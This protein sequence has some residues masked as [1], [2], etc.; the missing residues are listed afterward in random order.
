MK[1]I[2]FIV[3]SFCLTAM[4]FAQ[5]KGELKLW[6]NTP[7]KLWVEALPLGNGRIGAMVYGDPVH[8]QFQL[9]EET[10][11][12]GSPYNNTNPLAKDALSEIRQLIFEGKNAEAQKLCGPSICSQGANGMPYQ[13]LGSLH[14][15]FENIDKYENYYRELDIENATSKTTFST[16][17]INYTREAF[18][19][20]PDQL[21]IIRLTASKK[22]SISFT[23]RYTTPYKDATRSISDKMLRIDGKA[24]D[25]EKIEGK[26][27][28]AALTQINNNGGK[29][30]IT[31]DTTIR[32]TNAN[33]VILYVSMGT[34][35]INYKDVSGDALKTTKEYLKKANKKTFEKYLAAH[36]AYYRNFFDRVSLDLGRNAQADKTTDVRVSEFASTFDP[37][38][39]ALYFQFGR[40]LLICSS[41]PGGQAANL[42]GIWNYQLRAP[43][44]GKYTTDI[45]VEMNYWPAE[46][47]NL[48]EMHEPF[49]QLVKDVAQTGKES[50]AM[51]GCRGWTL[52]HNT[53][54]WRSTGAVDGP[55]YGIWPTCNA[56]FCQHLW[57]RYLFS[58]DKKYLNEVYPYMRDA[59]KFYLDF[60]VREPKNGWL[61]VAP[62]YSPENAPNVDGKRSWVVTAG[63]TMDN[64]MVFDLFSNTIQAAS[65]VNENQNF[66]DSL[67]TIVSQLPPM[68]VGR[69]GQL[70]EW[71]SDW[72]NPKDRHRHVSHLWGLY[73]GYQI[74]KFESPVLFEAAKKSLIHRG[75]PS[76][77]WSM[78]W[79]VCLWA[80]LLDGNHAYKLIADQLKPTVDEKGQNGGTY[81]N[82]FDAHPPFQI[83]GN[84]GC[85][86]GIA[87]ML[88]QSHGGAVHLLPAL[89]DVWSKGSVKGL[90]CRGGFELKEL[91]WE[92][93]KIKKAVIKSTQGGVLRIRS[94]VQL[95]LN[96]SALKEANGDNDNALFRM[97]QVRK[98]QVAA[99]A[100]INTADEYKSYLFDIVTE[101]GSSYTL[102]N[103]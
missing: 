68:Q 69:W 55:G 84:F 70:Q 53:D 99:S 39:A 81:P 62:S 83:D 61:V 91:T 38:L 26:V 9:N 98:P 82:L 89:P 87:E 65:L 15:D 80:R 54:I 73:P 76:T 96:G 22:N 3:L 25:H 92:N 14:L 17:G 18:T 29:L 41:Q 13:T 7:A 44:D 75:D 24:S 48:A 42:Q 52:H 97:Q 27:R 103:N 20:F 30:E 33:S 19:S 28:F 85:T 72:D 49:L 35:F 93:G 6:Y 8:E 21:L 45:N 2:S 56:W 90:R 23:A 74:S 10:I 34:N 32:V 86:A 94:A 51:Y 50:A 31:S 88:V 57:D 5:N 79:K 78:G 46:V 100:P 40:Y 37:Q 101:A 60:L 102:E 1:K 4:S 64:Q 67:N 77:G 16:N 59:C 71:M 63:C 66:I 47:T 43:W 36:S 11:W 95:S 12:G 58:G